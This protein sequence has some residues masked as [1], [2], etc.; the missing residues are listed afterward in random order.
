MR[1]YESLN[2]SIKY[3]HEKR[4]ELLRY[5]TQHEEGQCDLCSHET[6]LVNGLCP[7]CITKC[8]VRGEK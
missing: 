7:S 8:T 4:R 2:Q 1:D 3:E 6:H 5:S